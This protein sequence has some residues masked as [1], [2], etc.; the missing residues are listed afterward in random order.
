ML[1]GNLNS[2]VLTASILILKYIETFILKHFKIRVTILYNIMMMKMWYK[3]KQLIRQRLNLS[4]WLKVFK[5][6]K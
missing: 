2:Y 4:E 1:D 3:Q 6:R 5:D